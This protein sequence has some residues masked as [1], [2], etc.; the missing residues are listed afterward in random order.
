MSSLEAFSDGTITA[1]NAST[2]NDGAAMVVMTTMDYAKKHNLK[3][4]ARMLAYG[5]AATHPIDF[6]VAP[7]LVIPKILKMANLEVKD[8]DLWEINEAF[9]VVPLHS[10][11]TFHL[12][13]AKVNIHGGAVSLGHPIGMS[14]ARIIGHL[15]H[16]L[17]P[18][19]KGCAAIC[20]GGGGA[21]GM[22]IEG[23]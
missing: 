7:S 11:K 12:D 9:A 15:V 4:L 18:G 8:I 20:N 6:A 1:A 19:Q 5:D 23:L 22:I 3:P 14:G 2:L 10:M 13:H 17:K 16:T 21:G